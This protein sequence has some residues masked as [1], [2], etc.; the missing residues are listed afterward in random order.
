M[1]ELVGVPD[2]EIDLMTYKN[3]MRLFRYDP[4]RQI[5]KDQATVG[6]LR[7]QAVGVDLSLKSQGG[8]HAREEKGIVTAAQVAR[9]LAS[10]MTAAE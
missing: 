3:A 4:F 1:S 8:L 10:A 7:A 2:D 6:A 9:Q 5:T